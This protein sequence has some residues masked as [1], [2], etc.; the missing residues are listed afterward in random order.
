MFRRAFNY[1]H[2]SKSPEGCRLDGNPEEVGVSEHSKASCAATWA[3]LDVGGRKTFL[4][5]VRLKSSQN[6]SRHRPN[7]IAYSLQRQTYFLLSSCQ[8]DVTIGQSL[9]GVIPKTLIHSSSFRTIEI[10]YSEHGWF[11][12]YDSADFEVSLSRRECILC[13]LARLFIPAR[14]F[15]GARRLNIPAI[16]QGAAFPGVE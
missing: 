2:M 3:P 15:G 8:S 4:N 10:Q 5:A 12:F 13:L 16:R 11:G 14:Q 9:G 7:D 6:R 1:V